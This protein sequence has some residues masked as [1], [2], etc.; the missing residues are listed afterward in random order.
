M[1]KP[2][3]SIPDL[4]NNTTFILGLAHK[5]FRTLANHALQAECEITLEMLGAMRVLTHLGDIPQQQLAERLQR[6]RS[7]TKRLVDNCI[8]RG[9]IH[10]YKTDS[11]KK[12]R[13]L[14]LT[15]K[16]E[17]IKDQASKIIKRIIDDFLSPISEEEQAL[18]QAMC[19]KLIR[20]D[21]ILSA[22]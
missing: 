22:D 14:G 13:Y 9:L 18:L 1:Y 10:A 5:Q 17:E 3:I 15:E 21:L 19:K 8:K 11:N 16:G 20:D 7:V 2:S 6:E 12:A 4:D